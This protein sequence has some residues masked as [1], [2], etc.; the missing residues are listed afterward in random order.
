MS[1]CCCCWW[2]WW[3]SVC[4]AACSCLHGECDNRLSGSSGVCKPYSCTTGYT[5]VRCDIRVQTCGRRRRLRCHAFADCIT[6][7]PSGDIGDIFT[8]VVRV[9]IHAAERFVIQANET[10]R[11]RRVWCSKTRPRSSNS[12][13]SYM[14]LNFCFFNKIYKRD[15]TYENR[16]NAGFRLLSYNFWLLLILFGYCCQWR[17]KFESFN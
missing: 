17:K 16:Q 2:W 15:K 5:G 9:V 7:S 4:A 10:S 14:E 12:I 1:K 11:K 3:W 6:Q 8:Y 13:K